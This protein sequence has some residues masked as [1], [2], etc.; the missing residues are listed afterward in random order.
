MAIADEGGIEAL[1][2]RS[3]ATKLG[4]EAMSLYHHVANKEDILD[5]IVDMVFAEAGHTPEEGEWRP[6]IRAREIST[7]AVLMRH[8]WAVGLMDSRANLGPATM[9]HH[10]ARIGILRNNG[11]SMADIS[12]I[13]ATLD[14]YVFGFV[15]QER[16]LPGAAPEEIDVM[17][18]GLLDSHALDEY[19]HVRTFTLE[20]VLKRGFS[21]GAQFEWGLDLVLDGIAAQAD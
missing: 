14:A 8:R 2:M 7:R 4:V 21:F 16:S 3:I 1:S 18:Q 9:R 20:H 10:N 17:A 13:V 12:H 5:G 11:F 6:A 19:P 15:L